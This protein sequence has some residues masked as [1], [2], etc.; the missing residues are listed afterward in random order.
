MSSLPETP[1]L[2][3]RR[4]TDDDQDD[5]Y[6]LNSDPEVMKHI[7]NGTADTFDEVKAGL[8]R[9]KSYYH[10][11]PGFGIWALETKK[12]KTFIG[13][14]ML[15][16]LNGTPEVEVGYRLL[17][18]HWRRGYAMEAADALVRYGKDILGLKRIVATCYSENI[19]SVRIIEKLGL[20]FEREETYEGRTR[21]FY[22][23]NF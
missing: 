17:P 14:C 10:R 23:I 19:P 7:G 11:H 21:N 5:L 3:I 15:K 22:S 1:R 6:R 13:L 18:G 8:E 20:Q 12:E 9:I 4:M 2:I 16:Y